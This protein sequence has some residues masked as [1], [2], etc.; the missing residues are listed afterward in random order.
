[1]F[2]ESP[3]VIVQQ[4]YYK[5]DIIKEDSDD[6]KFFDIAVAANADYLVTNDNHF[7]Q[8]R[9]SV[10]PTVRIISA[11]DFLAIVQTL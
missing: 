1:V 8:A 6:N 9:Q 4:L 3:D 2:V 7:N 11:I 5:W 10:F